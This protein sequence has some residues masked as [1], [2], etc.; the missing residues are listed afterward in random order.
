MKFHAGQI[1]YYSDPFVFTIELVVIEFA[2]QDDVDPNLIYYIDN[3]GAY[4]AEKQLSKTLAEAKKIA[5]DGLDK[6]YD[7][8]R[9]QII[10]MYDVDN[11]G[12]NGIW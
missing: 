7:K 9:G 11:P 2:V 1:L 4:L 8:R 10:N 12:D 3:N 6:F 5:L